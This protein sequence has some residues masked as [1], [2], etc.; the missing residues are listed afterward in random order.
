MRALQL[1]H[2]RYLFELKHYIRQ[3]TVHRL[4]C[5]VCECDSTVR[6]NIPF[7]L[8]H[9]QCGERAPPRQCT[10]L[11]NISFHFI[12]FIILLSMSDLCAVSLRMIN[13]RTSK[14]KH[15]KQ[16]V[17]FLWTKSTDFSLLMLWF[18]LISCRFGAI[19]LLCMQFSVCNSTINHYHY[20][21]IVVSCFLCVNMSC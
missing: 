2:L 6:A 16:N 10:A 18:L 12:L 8:F 13:D 11:A 7:R 20:R 3:W 19:C 1:A 17:N 14:P 4:S 21:S 5:V 9:M 15:R